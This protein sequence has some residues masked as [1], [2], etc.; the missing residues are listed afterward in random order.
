MRADAAAV[1]RERRHDVVAAPA[2]ALRAQAPVRR[3]GPER[4]DVRRAPVRVVEEQRPAPLRQRLEPRGVEGA[5]L[6]GERRRRHEPRHDVVL[7]GEARQ[8]VHVAGAVQRLRV[9]RAADEQRRLAPDV[10]GE[11][12]AA[13]RGGD[14]VRRGVPLEAGRR[15]RER[16]A[17]CGEAQHCTKHCRAHLPLLLNIKEMLTST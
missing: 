4:R 13:R 6:D 8:Q 3:R 9:Q 10:G 17:E 7:E 1:G 14:A 2:R 12:R 16:R 11:L 5:D 15:E